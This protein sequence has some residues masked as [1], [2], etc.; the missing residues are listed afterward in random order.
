MT[1]KFILFYLEAPDDYTRADIDFKTLVEAIL[2]LMWEAE[3]PDEYLRDLASKF[4]YDSIDTLL[5]KLEN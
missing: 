3:E 4:L 2:I 5:I 1:G